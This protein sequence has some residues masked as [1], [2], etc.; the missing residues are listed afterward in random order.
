MPRIG[1][2]GFVGGAAALSAGLWLPLPGRAASAMD[3]DEARHLLSRTSFGATPAEIRA[4]EAQDYTSAVDRLLAGVR[5][6]AVT[7]A[8]AWISQGPA[9]L[10]RQ[11]Q[12]AV[13]EQKAGV[14]GKKLQVVASGPGRGP[15]AAQLVGRGDA[16]DRPAAHR[17]HGAVLA[18]PFHLL[19]PEGALSG[20]AAAAERAV[21]PPGARQFRDAPEGRGAR[22]GDADLSRRHAE[23]GASAQREFRPRASRAL[24]P[25]RGP[26]QRGRHQGRGARLHRLD[27]RPRN[28]RVPQP[29]P[30]ARRRREDLPRPDRPL[31]WRA[32]RRHPAAPS[33]HRR[34]DRREAVAR[35]RLA[36]ARSRPK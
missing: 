6:E 26:L 4:L 12:A 23:R 17:A 2:R 16:G 31:R 7:P 11:Q 19:V 5:R 15:R 13:A 14:D 8:P 25:G 10:R 20:G 30:R 34:D 33:A 3:F 36:E 18:Q 9:E 28:R 21:P 22:S 35:V 29:R 1:R 32:D 24:H 27:G